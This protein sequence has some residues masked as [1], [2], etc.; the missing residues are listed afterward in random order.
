MRFNA[1]QLAAVSRGPPGSF[2]KEGKLWVN[3]LSTSHSEKAQDSKERWCRLKGNLLFLMKKPIQKCEPAEVIILERYNVVQTKESSNAALV[4][5]SSERK[6]GLEMVEQWDLGAQ[7]K[8][9][10][11]RQ[12]S[13]SRSTESRPSA[14]VAFLTIQL[15]NQRNADTLSV[16]MR[17]IPPVP[18]VAAL[19]AAAAAAGRRSSPSPHSPSPPAPSVLL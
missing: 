6:K 4:I 2:D 12:N 14:N 15:F 13:V 9:L 19:L 8:T 11:V 18:F 17:R 16:Q 1:A 10:C 3:R 5:M 7:I